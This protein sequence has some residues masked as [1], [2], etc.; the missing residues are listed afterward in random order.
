MKYLSIDYGD[1]RL[2]VAVSDSRGKVAFPKQVVF[3]RGAR[4]LAD[5]KKIVEEEQV[6]RVVIGLP[7]LPGAKETEQTAKVR[8]FTESL[9]QVLAV[10]VD[11]EDELLTTHF[12]EKGPLRHTYTDAAAAAL[13]LQSYLDKLPG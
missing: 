5:L 9:K 8:N 13:I 10:G 11:F 4:T 7:K 3:N 12:I 6:S 1:K 2:G